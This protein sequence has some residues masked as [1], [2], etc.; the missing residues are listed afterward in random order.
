MIGIYVI[1]NF[2]T[3][4]SYIG[5]S[6]DAINRVKEHIGE[7]SRGNHSSILM[8]EDYID[9]GE[10][11][12]SYE[13]LAQCSEKHLLDLEQFFI[14]KY[15]PEYNTCSIAG[16]TK[17]FNK[18]ERYTIEHKQRILRARRG[19]SKKEKKYYKIVV[20]SD[21]KKQEFSSVIECNEKLGIPKS[22]IFNGIKR[23]NLVGNKYKIYKEEITN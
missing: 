1:V 18:S 21:G 11:S 22:T 3:G 14:N 4:N 7:L 17:G 23:K 5:S 19:L 2:K 9:H 12:F 8:Q 15:N 10:D 20:E 6:R 16:S 13:I